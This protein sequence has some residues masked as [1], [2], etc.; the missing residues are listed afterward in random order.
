[1]NLVLSLTE[2][3]EGAAQTIKNLPE[4]LKFTIGREGD[5]VPL[6][7]PAALLSRIHATCTRN[8]DGSWT[9]E[10][11]DGKTPSRN[12]LWNIHGSRV[13]ALV[14][15]DPGDYADLL[16]ITGG[17]IM[18]RVFIDRRA[19]DMDRETLGGEV[20]T[21]ESLDK[22]LEE[23]CT[24]VAGLSQEMAVISKTQARLIANDRRQDKSLKIGMKIL[25]W[26]AAATMGLIGLSAIDEKNRDDILKLAV[27]IALSGTAIGGGV[28]LKE[29]QKKD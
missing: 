19:G 24:C 9:V 18:V 13:K 16:K 4:A 15:R 1:M 27:G 5:I 8:A 2:Q 6:V 7:K 25:G 3:N 17:G 12:G 21:L 26:V 22:K 14:L 29:S 10:D 20:Y 23:L 11:G 28:V